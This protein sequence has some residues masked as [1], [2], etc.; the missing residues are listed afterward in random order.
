MLT[1]AKARSAKAGDKDYKLGDSGGLYLFVTRNGYKSWRLKYRFAEKE[2]RLVFG[3]YPEVSIAEARERR[4]AA[5]RLLR[6]H[7]DPGVEL[8]K[9]RAAAHSSHDATFERVARSWHESQK[10]LWAPVHASD[11]IR[12]LE[13]DIFPS[14]G[15]LPVRDIDVPFVLQT[16]RKIEARDAIETAKRVRQRMSAVFVY[17]ISEGIASADPAAIVAKALKPKRKGK[18]Q[19]AILDVEELR[20]LLRATDESGASP[21]TK[22]ASRLLALTAVR[23]G[24]IRGASWDEFEGLDGDK[25]IWRIPADRMTRTSTARLRLPSTRRDAGSSDQPAS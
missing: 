18:K 14:L 13:R 12:S 10:A 20:A 3:P 15:A 21:V 24:V 22:L 2:K 8:L 11:V 9:Q 6:D 1:D 23:P 25:A 17:A 16:L 4:D 7:C 19:P 5:R